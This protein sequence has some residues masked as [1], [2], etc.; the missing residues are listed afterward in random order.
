MGVN[1]PTLLHEI[2]DKVRFVNRQRW[3]RLAVR[4]KKGESAKGFFDSYP[5]FFTTSSTNPHRDR[6]N[7]RHRAMIESNA[8]IIAGRRILD[9]ASHDGRWSF[10]AH[11]A[12]AEHV[13]GIEARTH[14]IESARGNVRQ[15]E[16]SEKRV[17]FVQGD[18]LTA[19]DSL[20]A[21][22]FDTVFCFGFLYHTIDHMPL[23]RKIA[24]LGPRNLVID[25]AIAIGPASIIEV[26]EEDIA[27]E[28]AGAVG[29]L[30]HPTM[31]VKG[32]PTRSALELMLRAAGF[33]PVRYYDWLQAGIKKWDTL[34]DYYVGSR[35]T[36]TCAVG[37]EREPL[38]RN[39]K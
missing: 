9:I 29:E 8:G 7:Q 18:A 1:S 2:R 5:R 25:T 3:F 39:G 22:S 30:G 14:L 35:I 34:S 23:L 20:P 17:E 10:A 13:L 11:M 32:R 4:G 28:S 36:L 6:L 24:R 21:G 12:G 38:E 26:R 19:L 16:V 31:T 33:R 27:P 15:Y 37:G